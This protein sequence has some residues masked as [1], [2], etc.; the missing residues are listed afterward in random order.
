MLIRDIIIPILAL[1]GIWTML[2]LV[3]ITNLYVTIVLVVI[4]ILVDLGIFLNWR[5]TEYRLTTKR[6]ESK[7]G[8][9][10]IAREEIYLEDIQSIDTKKSFMGI[11]F[12]FGDVIIEAAGHNSVTLVKV[13]NMKTIADQIA[14][15]SLQHAKHRKPPAA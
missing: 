11:I 14:D 10:S 7:S 9:F 3:G 12:N 13:S 1:G 4:I 8:L 15:L 5:S 6:I 2:T